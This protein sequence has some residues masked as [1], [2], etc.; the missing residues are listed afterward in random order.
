MAE[1]AVYFLIIRFIKPGP[2]DLCH[3]R[4]S[5]YGVKSIIKNK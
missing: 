2:F 1:A 5:G 4:A 3:P